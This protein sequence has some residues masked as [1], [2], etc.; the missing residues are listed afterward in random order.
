MFRELRETFESNQI[1]SS[2]C[3]RNAKRAARARHSNHYYDGR[4]LCDKLVAIAR[5]LCERAYRNI[6]ICERRSCHI[7]ITTTR[8]IV[9][10]LPEALA[11]LSSR[12]ALYRRATH[13]SHTDVS[14]RCHAHNRFRSQ[15]PLLAARVAARTL[16]HLTWTRY[17]TRIVVEEQFRSSE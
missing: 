7:N 9:S 1:K 2:A 6:Y 4:R 10:G 5:A 17:D 8:Y 14:C 12:R 3:E 13:V 11:M 16:N 15:H